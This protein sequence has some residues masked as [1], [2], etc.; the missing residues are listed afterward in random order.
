M[1]SNGNVPGKS[2]DFG[3]LAKADHRFGNH[4]GGN[5]DKLSEDDQRHRLRIVSLLAFAYAALF[6]STYRIP[7][8]KG[9]LPYE[10]APYG[11]VEK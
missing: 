2:I 4:R 11:G 1:R 3:S 6:L 5:E 9:A 10:P 7:S 8:I